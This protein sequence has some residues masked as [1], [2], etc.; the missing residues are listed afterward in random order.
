MLDRLGDDPVEVVHNG[1]AL[2]DPDHRLHVSEVQLPEGVCHQDPGLVLPGGGNAVLQV[3]DYG[4]GPGIKGLLHEPRTVAG[5]VEP[6]PP[7]SV[8]F[9]GDD[10]LRRRQPWHAATQNHPRCS[11]KTGCCCEWSCTT[12]RYVHAAGGHSHALGG[13]PYGR[14]KRDDLSI[15]L[16]LNCKGFAPGTV[17]NRAVR[18]DLGSGKSAFCRLCH[19]SPPFWK[20]CGRICR[21]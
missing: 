20:L 13:L 2:V 9:R 17:D 18:A 8:R 16:Y 11:L 6:G 10:D 3:K 4:I 12:V 15:G 14:F 19:E 5:D 21:G 1:L 7:G